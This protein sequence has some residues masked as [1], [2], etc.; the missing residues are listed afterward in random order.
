MK[1][2]T[3]TLGFL[4]VILFFG[5][6]AAKSYNTNSSVLVYDSLHVGLFDEY[7]Q[8]GRRKNILLVPHSAKPDDLTLIVWF[9]GLNGFSE[10]TFDR[11]FKQVQRASS[12]GHSVAVVIPEMPWSTNT[13]TPRGRQ[14][15]VWRKENQFKKFID[16]ASEHV[17]Q[18]LLQSHDFEVFNPDI[19]VI[20]HSAGGSAIMS[21]SI[22]GS[23]CDP[24][25]KKVVWSDASYGSWLFKS[26]KGCLGNTEALQH[27]VVRK[28]DKPYVRAKKF[29]K[30]NRAVP[31]Y[32]LRV[33]DRKKYTHG[34]IGDKIMS[35][36]KLF[37]PTC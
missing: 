6:E 17:K 11:V 15:K 32:N 2:L 30:L 25:V 12:E 27:I 24:R 26:H 7:H 28:W 14:G 4:V 9:H 5:T 18:V 22:E 16:E 8:E 31:G 34:G 37:P 21:A 19:V 3:L 23:I 36:T 33:L 20:G 10:K 13:S 29:L 1:I 35:I